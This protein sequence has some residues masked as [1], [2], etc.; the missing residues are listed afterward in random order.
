[1][2][3]KVEYPCLLKAELGGGG[4]AAA[5]AA[6]AA[7]R[8]TENPATPNFGVRLMTTRKK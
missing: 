3:F 1:M 5:L 8:C 2:E 7:L 6:E 4:S